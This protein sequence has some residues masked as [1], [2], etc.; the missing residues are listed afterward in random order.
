MRQQKS[1]KRNR[2]PGILLPLLFTS[3]V[4]GSGFVGF[5]AAGDPPE[6]QERAF[7]IRASQYGYDPAV[8]R[9]NRGDTVRMRLV[10]MDVVHGFYLEGHDLDVAII[11]MRSTV[12]LRRPSRPGEAESVEEVVFTAGQEGKFRYRCSQTCGFLHPFMLG[13]LIVAPNRLLPVSMGLAVGVLLGGLIVIPLKAS[14][15]L[16]DGGERA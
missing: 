1:V 9:V 13:E 3:V 6:A 15:S 8:I 11:P 12:E 5:L 2:V 16:R 14:R 7:T 10:S 4:T